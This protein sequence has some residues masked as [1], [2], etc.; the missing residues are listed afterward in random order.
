MQ[1]ECAQRAQSVQ[2]LLHD[3]QQETT[4]QAAHLSAP[5][6]SACSAAALGALIPGLPLI[7]YTVR[8]VQQ[9]TRILCPTIPLRFAPLQPSSS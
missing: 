7:H 1:P 3:L 6:L 4:P 8:N 5:V 9:L 2:M